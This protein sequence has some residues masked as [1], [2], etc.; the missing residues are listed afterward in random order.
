M[1]CASLL[2]SLDWKLTLSRDL[3]ALHFWQ[4]TAGWPNKVGWEVGEEDE[5]W[6]EEWNLS[7]LQPWSTSATAESPNETVGS[8]FQIGSTLANGAKFVRNPWDDASKAA[9]AATSA[10]TVGVTCISGALWQGTGHGDQAGEK[11]NLRNRSRRLEAVSMNKSGS[12]FASLLWTFLSKDLKNFKEWGSK[13][14]SESSNTQLGGQDRSIDKDSSTRPN[15][16]GR[17]IRSVWSRLWRS[18][19]F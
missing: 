17:Q 9:F 19:G 16:G 4:K 2:N 18:L 5:I 14:E 15:K 1:L 13:W 3:L 6:R 10:F 11:E 7:A 12:L 8:L